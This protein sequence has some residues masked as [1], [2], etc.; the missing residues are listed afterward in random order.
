MEEDMK[1]YESKMDFLDRMS[2]NFSYRLN[3]K[4]SE[5]KATNFEEEVAKIKEKIRKLNVDLSE[6]K[7]STL[8]LIK[9]L[10]QTASTTDFK[11]VKNKVDDWKLD[12]MITKKEFKKLIQNA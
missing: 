8:Y 1:K 11:V 3:S 9:V 5:T 4:M 6:L 12:Q 7:I 2:N 10:K